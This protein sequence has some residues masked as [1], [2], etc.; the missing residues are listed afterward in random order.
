MALFV[1]HKFPIFPL[2][3][4]GQPGAAPV[5]SD[6]AFADRTL[7]SHAFLSLLIDEGVT[8]LFGNPGTTELPVMAALPEFP[9]IEYVLGAQEAAVVAMAD[10]YARASGTLAACNVHVAPGLG[11]AMGSLFNAHWIG[12]PLIVTAGQHEIGHGLT[13]PMLYAPLEPM[14]RPVVKWSVEVTRLVDLPRIIRRAA[15]IALAPPTGPVFVSLPGDVMNDEAVV[16]LG[17]RNRV[18]AR[19]RPADTTLARLAE[20]LLAATRPVIV[21]GHDV[22]RRD[23]LSAAGELAQRLGA[24]VY[25]DTIPSGAPFVSTHVCYHGMLSRD[26][27]DVSRRLSDYD[28]LV[29]LGTDVLRMSVPGSVAPIPSGLPIVQIG[30]RSDDLAKNF[31]TELA[32]QAD[33]LET[34]VALNTV[35]GERGSTEHRAAAAARVIRMRSGNWCSQRSALVDTIGAKDGAPMHPDQLMLRLADAMPDDAVIVD[36]GLTST[37]VLPQLFPYRDARSYY[38]LASGGIGFA[39]AGAV[40]IRLAI[41]DRPV[42][43]VIGDGSAMYNIQALWTAAHLG[44][45]LVYVIANNG[46]YRILKQRVR[47][48]HGVERFIGMDFTDP[49]IDF[50]ALAGSMGVRASRITDADAVGPALLEALGHNGPTLLDVR[51]DP[52][53]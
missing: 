9:Q 14:A 41:P 1:G 53:L 42:V 45:R 52:R 29:C 7:G 28:L 5:N 2:L 19:T 46:G 4:P 44:L 30:E 38:G 43:A 20:R 15:K 13:E 21:C 50:A 35:L 26:Q 8:H 31:P 16:D 10:G 22:H 18:D 36:E 11:N 32:L 51:V 24:A 3:A 49:S 34:L 33:V 23:A 6:T 12:A 25:Q 47:A 48:G 37:R 27:R 40:G 17:T 39:V